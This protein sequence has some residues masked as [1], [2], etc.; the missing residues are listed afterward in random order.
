MSRRATIIVTA[1][2]AAEITILATAATSAPGYH[3]IIIP[4][5]SVGTAQVIYRSLLALDFAKNQLPAR[6]NRNLIALSR[7]Q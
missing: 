3:Q 6:T 1:L 5:N 7:P 2:V 4:P